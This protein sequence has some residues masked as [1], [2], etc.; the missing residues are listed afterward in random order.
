MPKN[1]IHIRS[2]KSSYMLDHAGTKLGYSPKVLPIIFAWNYFRYLD[3]PVASIDFNR[4]MQL[5]PTTG[6]KILGTERA[7][8]C[9]ENSQPASQP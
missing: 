7:G 5:L 1:I 3:Y 4:S 8:G 2:Y 6:S 9:E